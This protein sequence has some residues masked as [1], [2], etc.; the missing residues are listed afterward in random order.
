MGDGDRGAPVGLGRDSS[1]TLREGVTMLGF[2]V[3]VYRQT[4][5]GASAA[6]FESAEGPRLAVW[7]TDVY[8]LDWLDELVKA[9]K[10]I[11]L[12]GT[13]YPLRYT[14]TAQYLVRPLLDGPPGAHE[15]WILRV[16][17]TVTEKWEGKTAIDRALVKACRPDEW[18][19][20]EAWDES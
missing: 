19:I 8:G 3:T 6:T 16:G 12:G 9:G 15:T 14:A 20:V 2:H 1:F 5:D 17:D 7:Q 18:L 10:A 13:G 4:D 11:D